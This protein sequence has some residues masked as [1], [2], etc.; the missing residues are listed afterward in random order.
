MHITHLKND[1]I[2]LAST[3]AYDTHP[4][5]EYKY[6][7]KTPFS[8]YSS[9]DYADKTLLK[10]NGNIHEV[11]LPQE[12]KDY[13]P[14]TAY[15]KGDIVK[16]DG[17]LQIIDT[18]SLED[19]QNFLL[20]NEKLV[21]SRVILYLKAVQDVPKHRD[22]DDVMD[23]E[24]VTRPCQFYQSGGNR[25][26]RVIENFSGDGEFI[27]LTS[28]TT[29]GSTTTRKY[30]KYI[31]YTDD[32][33]IH[34]KMQTFQSDTVMLLCNESTGCQDDPSIQWGGDYV[35][36][37]GYVGGINDMDSMY[38]VYGGDLY[39]RFIGSTGEDIPIPLS[40]ARYWETYD[41]LDA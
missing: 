37:A 11:N 18:T 33:G 14:F 16:Y 15:K 32:S 23:V 10:Y 5:A 22:Y 35:A 17:L 30:T 27:C 3:N 21:S 12:Y 39:R 25:Y 28:I 41:I 7:G 2:T 40:D 26:Q 34:L 4:E 13:T 8:S 1:G 31:F 6:G 20:P 29:I 9:V 38:F 36:P 24:K 19:S